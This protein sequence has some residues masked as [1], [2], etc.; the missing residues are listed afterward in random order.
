MTNIELFASALCPFAARARLAFAEKQLACNEVEIDLRRKPDWFLRISPHGKVPL[1]RHD[2]R[3]VWESAVIAEYLEEAFPERPLLPQD[4]ARR[5]QARAWV[6]F[7]DS[8]L[9]AKTAALLHSFDD[10]LY[11]RLAAQIVDDLHTL[12]D[13]AFG[14][15]M[16]DG[17]YVLG[18]E[19]TL[20]DVA[21][22]PWF[23]Q[24]A[25][26]EQFRGFRFPSDCTRLLAWHRAMASRKAVRSVNRPAK[27]YLEGYAQLQKQLAG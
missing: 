24:V 1:L 12:E 2:G 7:A 6:N 27:F 13:E 9:Y 19:F 20:A 14:G 16:N 22:Y 21:L 18:S 10:H 3:L 4:P 5:A 25:V 26:L 11:V 8:R 23:E 17:P 15:Q